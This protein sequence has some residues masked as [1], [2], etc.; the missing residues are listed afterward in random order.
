MKK[1]IIA[2]DGPAGSGKST[3]AKLVAKKLGFVYLDTGAMYRA[4]TLKA[5]R[6]RINPQDE[7]KLSQIARNSKLDLIEENG[8]NKVILDGADVTEAIREPK[9]NRIVSEVSVHKEVRTA[10]VA[11]QKE[12]GKKHNL[13]TE[14]RDTTTVVFPGASLKV[15]LDCNLKERAKRRMLE[16][17]DKGINTS[18][19]EQIKELS[20]RD[21]IDSE[22]ENSPL[23]KD[24][25]ALIVDTTN[26]S[27]EEQ[28]EKV[29]QLYKLRKRN[30]ISLPSS[31]VSD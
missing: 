7:K 5:L 24:K 15:Y 23:K 19:E 9:V 10:L 11:K 29:T 31:P 16:L 8:V 26:L 2:I 28:V 1:E 22:R 18:I 12:L 27:V 30:E 14:G 25:E 21:K 6:N 4:I 3:T 20:R 13:V 17:K